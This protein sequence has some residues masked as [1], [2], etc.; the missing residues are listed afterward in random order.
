[1]KKV[2]M[3]GV[4]LVMIAISAFVCVAHAHAAEQTQEPTSEEVIVAKLD[5]IAKSQAEIKDTLASIQNQLEL[6][7]MRITQIQ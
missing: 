2:L 5:E 6:I 7:K 1:M 4:V 3:A